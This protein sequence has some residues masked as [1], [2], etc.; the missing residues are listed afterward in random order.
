MSIQEALANYH[1][2]LYYN[3]EWHRLAIDGDIDSI[4]NIGT[5]FAR[6]EMMDYA[7]A[8]WKYVIDIGH[9][10]AE[11]YSNLGVSYYYGNGV[12]QDYMKAVQYY[13]RAAAKGHPLG[14]YNLAVACENGNGTPK[15]IE[16]AITLYRRAATQ[17][18]SMAADALRRLGVDSN[19]VDNE[20]ESFI[21]DFIGDE[22]QRICS[23]ITGYEEEWARCNNNHKMNM[24]LVPFIYDDERNRSITFEDI[25]SL[26]DKAISM[27]P[28]AALYYSKG[29]MYRYNGDEETA[30]ECYKKSIELDADDYQAL[31]NLGVMFYNKEMDQFALECFLKS[32]EIHPSSIVYRNLS[33]VY[34]VL[35]D[36]EKSEKYYQ[37][38]MT[39]DEYDN[40]YVF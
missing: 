32:A 17:N 4:V 7:V 14:M 19:G 3:K 20:E 9:G 22:Y 10:T 40:E 29:N 39:I 33:N 6:S 15:D 38:A 13:Q 36:A 34:K 30:I 11:A 26:I 8:C 1:N 31:C 25:I 27:K 21:D 5:D 35:G 16:K 12:S 2:S 28:S 24:V 37:M 23:Q 18:I